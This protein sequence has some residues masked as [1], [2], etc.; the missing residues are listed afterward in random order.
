MLMWGMKYSETFTSM[1][2]PKGMWVTGGIPTVEEKVLASKPKNLSFA[3]AASL[4]VAVEIAYGGLESAGLS[5][6]K[7]LLVL[8][9]AGGVG[10]FIIQVYAAATIFLV[11]FLERKGNFLRI[12][13]D[14]DRL[15]P[16]ES[17][18]ALVGNEPKNE[19]LL[20]A[21]SFSHSKLLRVRTA[22][23]KL[24][25]LQN[26]F[27]KLIVLIAVVLYVSDC[28]AKIHKELSK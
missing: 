23:A 20:S 28:N 8:G 22:T 25:F 7:S 1:F 27:F 17:I 15:S 9:G 5:T 11:P 18:S 21:T 16:I 19:G 12:G 14:S 4:P 26:L 10:S 6:G 13:N 2:V 24:F 3:E